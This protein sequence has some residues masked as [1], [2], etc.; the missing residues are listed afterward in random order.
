MLFFPCLSIPHVS[1][2]GRP[3]ELKDAHSNSRPPSR[4]HGSDERLQHPQTSASSTLPQSTPHSRIPSKVNISGTHPRPQTP[5]HPFSI[6]SHESPRPR[7][8]PKHLVHVLKSPSTSSSCCCTAAS[9]PRLATRKDD[10][11]DLRKDT[12]GRSRKTPFGGVIDVPSN[13]LA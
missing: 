2:H 4:R 5:S 6:V 7:H 8:L 12:S 9:L 10:F 3:H 13:Y 1:G 11:R